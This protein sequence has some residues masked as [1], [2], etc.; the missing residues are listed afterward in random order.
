MNVVKP[1]DVCKVN[2]RTARAGIGNDLAAK[3]HRR[4]LLAVIR[5]G[6][7]YV[8]VEMVGGEW[9]YVTANE[10]HV[11]ALVGGVKVP[12]KALTPVTNRK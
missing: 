11:S 3:H 8:R 10:N 4:I 7:G 5:Q 2:M 9:A 6:D 12:I 1:G